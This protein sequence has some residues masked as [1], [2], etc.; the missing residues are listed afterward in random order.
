MEVQSILFDRNHWTLYRA[1]QWL[2]K[3]GYKS[4]V[5]TKPKF[6]RFR[7]KTPKP[8]HRY[9]TKQVTKGVHFIF[10]S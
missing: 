4:S 7:Q 8:S 5:D 6:Y 2:K 10:I 1:K 3:H 9:A